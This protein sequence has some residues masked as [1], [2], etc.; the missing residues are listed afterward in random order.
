[1]KFRKAE[2]DSLDDFIQ[3]VQQS[4]AV[5]KAQPVGSSN[6]ELIVETLDWCSYF[7]TLFKKIKGIK[8]FQHFVVNAPHLV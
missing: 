2:V 1:E 7:A 6:G 8:G 4:S 3:V 5:N